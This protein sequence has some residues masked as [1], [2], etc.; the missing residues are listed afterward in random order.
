MDTHKHWLYFILGLIYFVS[1]IVFYGYFKKR[2]VPIIFYRTN[3]FL[4][5]LSLPIDHSLFFVV[6]T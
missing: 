5:I 1:K 2:Q 4:I 6:I 3:T